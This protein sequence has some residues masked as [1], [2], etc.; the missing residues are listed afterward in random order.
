MKNILPILLV[1]SLIFTLKAQEPLKITHFEILNN[2]EWK[3]QLTY[4]DYQSGLPTSIDATMQITIK[5]DRLIT[6][7]Q[8]TYEPNKNNSSSVK[9]KN[10]GTYFGN[11]KL[12]SN[13]LKNGIRTFVTTYSGKDNGKKANMYV[14]HQFTESS[15]TVT[16]EVQYLD[17]DE[18]FVR[19]TYEFNKIL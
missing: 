4:K 1:I 12:L 3:G 16:K 2:T 13:I 11:E 7:M 9:I 15:Y 14:T 17:S 5:N 6:N 18:R 8:Y 19:N 10:N